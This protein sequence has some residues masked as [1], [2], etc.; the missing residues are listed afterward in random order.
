LT[1][2]LMAASAAMTMNIFLPSLTA[3]SVEFNTSYSTAQLVLSGYL[4]VTAVVQLIIGP[5]SDR[6]GRRPVILVAYLFFMA[7]SLICAMA[8][9][10]E[11]LLFGRLVQAAS[12][13]SMALARA[14][15][16]DLFTRSKAASMIG[17]V[18]MAMAIG[19]MI[20]PILGGFYRTIIP[21]APAF[22]FFLSF[23]HSC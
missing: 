13:T 2:V 7:G 15:I 16:R 14:I 4:G 3:I 8:P 9:S 23:Q 5:L 10:M 22:C 20:A 19:P 12:A 21:G 18:T 6:F 1:I 17:Y 11:V